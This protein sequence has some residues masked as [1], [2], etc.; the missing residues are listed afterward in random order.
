MSVQGKINSLFEEKEKT[1]RANQILANQILGEKVEA[2]SSLIEEVKKQQKMDGM[3][4]ITS[5]TS[6]ELAYYQSPYFE[7]YKK[8]MTDII[9]DSVDNIYNTLVQIYNYNIYYYKNAFMKPIED[10]RIIKGIGYPIP[11][12]FIN[13]LGYIIDKKMNENINLSDIEC[14]IEI[15]P[16]QYL[17]DENNNIATKVDAYMLK[18]SL[19]RK[20]IKNSK[21]I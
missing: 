14:N 9:D 6:E 17:N 10:R 21:T 18:V 20:V 16:C 8:L 11:V 7:N 3:F 12:K 13:Q 19:K 4:D 2:N 15:M 1:D 5:F